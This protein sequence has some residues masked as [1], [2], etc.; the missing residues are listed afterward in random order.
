[1]RLRRPRLDAR[2]QLNIRVALAAQIEQGIAR[3]KDAERETDILPLSREVAGYITA[4][5][6]MIPRGG[7]P[8]AG[9][10]QA[11]W[12]ASSLSAAITEAMART[13]RP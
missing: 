2:D 10:E 3:I 4:Y 8:V 13:G 5:H 12:W 1:M 7:G 11:S 6:H 9:R